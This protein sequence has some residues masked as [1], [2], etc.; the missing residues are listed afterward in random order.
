MLLRTLRDVSV[1]GRRVLIREDFNVP[2]T[3]NGEIEDD[4]KIKASLTTI[5]FVL[6]NDGAVILMSHLGRPGGKYVKGLSLKI[7]ADRLKVLLNQEVLFVSDC[8]GENTETIVS[9]L[10][11]GQVALLENLRFYAGEQ[12]PKQDASFASKLARLGD[13]YVNDAFAIVHEQQ[14]SNFTI[15]PHYAISVGGFLMEKEV[16]VLTNLLKQV[17]SPFYLIIGGNKFSK[18][19]LLESLLEKVDG[20][21]VGGE[22]SIPFLAFLKK[23]IAHSFNEKNVLGTVERIFKKAKKLEVKLRFPVDFLIAKNLSDYSD[24]RMVSVDDFLPEGWV[25]GDIGSKSIMA[26]KEEMQLANAIFWNGPLGACEF[27]PFKEGTEQVARMMAE[28]KAFTLVGGG[29]AAGVIYRLGLSSHIN[30]V[31]TGG[32][33]SL[34]FIKQQNLPVLEI[35]EKGSIQN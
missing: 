24:F 21:F 10:Q 28:I 20:I 5:Q 2:L 22:I 33:A 4:S 25:C 12:H 17:K 3:S 30:F 31:S 16:I 1:K 27:K 7:V 8:I 26:W 29:S 13:I 18:I 34:A 35:L 15:V 32:G 23:K 6:V 14:A 9:R 19:E 11:P